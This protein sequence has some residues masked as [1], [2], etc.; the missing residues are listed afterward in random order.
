M[1]I[2]ETL[3]IYAAIGAAVAGALAWRDRRRA[4]LWLTV[5]LAF[6]PLFLPFLFSPPR[7]SPPTEPAADGLRAEVEGLTP[8]PD[9][10]AA[11]PSAVDAVDRMQEGV[12][13]LSR[14]LAQQEAAL[15]ADE[16]LLSRSDRTREVLESRRADLGRLRDARDEQEELALRLTGQVREAIT[17]AHLSR[18]GGATSEELRKLM[19]RMSDE[20]RM[21]TKKPLS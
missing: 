19:A 5:G 7:R 13:D 14:L 3:V 11:L 20:F 18:Y 2:E 15:D 21:A 8:L 6:W 16:P 4:G 12:E 1:R 10:L 17:K 9:E